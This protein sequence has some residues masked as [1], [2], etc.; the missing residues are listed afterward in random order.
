MLEFKGN[1]CFLLVVLFLYIMFL[2]K[3]QV[4]IVYLKHI[5]IKK[6]QIS[7]TELNYLTAQVCNNK[8]K[9]CTFT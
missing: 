7:Q 6:F 9:F 5:L 2:R 1:N 8:D 4:L 3:E